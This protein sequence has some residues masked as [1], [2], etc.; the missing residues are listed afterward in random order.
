MFNIFNIKKKVPT[1]WRKYYTDD[2]FNIKL[3]NISLYEQVYRTRLKYGKFK[4]YQ[5]FGKKVS[6]KKFIKQIDRC[7][8]SLKKLNL[9]KG[10]IVT[11]CLPNIPEALILFYALNKMGVIANMLHPLS[12]EEEI[13]QSL[14]RTNSKY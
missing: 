10:D 7:S 9:K 5:Y 3:P 4:S 8:Y 14:N 13:K 12:A 2:E 1:P 11:I 6:Y